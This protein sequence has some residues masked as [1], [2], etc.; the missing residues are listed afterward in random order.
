MCS[1]STALFFAVI[2]KRIL[3]RMRGKETGLTE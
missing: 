1:L 2:S 3:L